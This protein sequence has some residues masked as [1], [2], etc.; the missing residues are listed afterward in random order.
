MT[1]TSEHH[2]PR[3]ASDKL[4]LGVVAVYAAAFVVFGFLVQP[5]VDVLRGV[6]AILTTATRCSPTISASAESVGAA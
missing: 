1:E 2:E 6:S 3:L 5:P 4:I